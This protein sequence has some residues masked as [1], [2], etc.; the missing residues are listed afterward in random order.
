MCRTPPA[1]WKTTQDIKTEARLFRL[2]LKSPQ[3]YLLCSLFDSRTSICGGNWDQA[4][5]YDAIQATK[6]LSVC[7]CVSQS[8][9]LDGVLLSRHLFMWECQ[10]KQSAVLPPLT[11]SCLVFYIQWNI[12]VQADELLEFT[13]VSDSIVRFVYFYKNLSDRLCKPRRRNVHLQMCESFET[14]KIH[15][16]CNSLISD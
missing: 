9:W 1:S 13:H 7:V 6:C 8:R 5:K 14:A 11:A 2:F 3:S 12:A 4:V 16:L 15:R 10:H